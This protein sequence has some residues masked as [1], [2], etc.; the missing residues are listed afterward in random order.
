MSRASRPGRVLVIADDAASGHGHAQHDAD[1]MTVEI[2]GGGSVPDVSAYDQVLVVGIAEPDRL[3]G[4]V[5]ALLAAPRA[6]EVLVGGGVAPLGTVADWSSALDAFG[7]SGFDGGPLA[8]AVVDQAGNG[9]GAVVYGLL[10][11]SVKAT[12][13]LV[14]PPRAATPDVADEPAMQPAEAPSPVAAAGARS[15]VA[16]ILA[17]RKDTLRAAV[18][19]T[20][21]VMAVVA[22]LAGVLG[23]AVI[24][25]VLG[26]VLVAVVA[27][28][29]RAE[30]RRSPAVQPQ[31]IRRLEKLL[32][33]Q[34]KMLEDHSEQLA[35]LRTSTSINELA[36]VDIAKSLVRDVS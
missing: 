27:G 36:T 14:A 7:V 29:V 18:V 34:T 24:G 33:R 15:R 5:G 23:D 4:V 20:V 32:D 25:A 8:L 26:L 31:H 2:L 12:P 35:A 6:P 21:V 19:V 3:A 13:R 1:E 11:A 30:R 10:A 9:A 28:A 22:V 16:K 17:S